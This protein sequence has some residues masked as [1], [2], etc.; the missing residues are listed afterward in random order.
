MQKLRTVR[1]DSAQFCFVCQEGVGMGDVR[2]HGNRKLPLAYRHKHDDIGAVRLVLDFG[3][4]L[5]RVVFVKSFRQKRKSHA[6]HPLVKR[7]APLYKGQVF[8]VNVSF[9]L[10]GRVLR[11]N[12]LRRTFFCLAFYEGCLHRF[13]CVYS[14]HAGREN[15]N[16]LPLKNYANTSC[17]SST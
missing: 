1:Y 7:N 14:I 8:S 10:L 12:L 13:L 11:P 2:P 6:A 4:L 3:K 16:L 17:T 9:V 15:V 5:G